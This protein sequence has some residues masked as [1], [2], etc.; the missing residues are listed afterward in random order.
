MRAA[1]SVLTNPDRPSSDERFDRSEVGSRLI[2]L[3]QGE[4]V[5]VWHA[6]VMP[7]DGCSAPPASR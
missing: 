5:F 2:G 6:H 1:V 3:A 7:E 4:R